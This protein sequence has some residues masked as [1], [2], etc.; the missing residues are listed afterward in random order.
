MGRENKIGLERRGRAII[1][2][3]MP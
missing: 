1:V 3:L 2:S